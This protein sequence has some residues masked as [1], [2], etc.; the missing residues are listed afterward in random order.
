[1]KIFIKRLS[2][3]AVCLFT[4]CSAVQP[5]VAW[6]E[7]EDSINDVGWL[8]EDYVRSSEIAFNRLG[9]LHDKVDIKKWEQEAEKV[10]VD[11]KKLSRS[12]QKFFQRIFQAFYSL[13]PERT[14]LLQ[15]GLMKLILEHPD[16]AVRLE[17]WKYIKENLRAFDIEKNIGSLITNITGYRDLLFYALSKAESDHE[18]SVWL[19]KELRSLKYTDNEINTRLEAFH[20]KDTLGKAFEL[21]PK[22]P[23]PIKDSY[24][25]SVPGNSKTDQRPVVDFSS[26]MQLGEAGVAL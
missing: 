11:P 18:L 21:M 1:M 12:D 23:Q 16:P 19:R 26:D 15:K 8:I 10:N 7:D 20:L 17:A 5:W 6:A 3:I 9:P 24:V 14:P 22:A 2:F 4:I 13:N 25:F